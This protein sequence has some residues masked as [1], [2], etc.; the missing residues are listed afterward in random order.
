MNAETL[1]Q[2]METVSEVYQNFLVIVVKDGVLSEKER[3][4]YKSDKIDGKR[5]IDTR[6]A[7]LMSLSGKGGWCENPEDRKIREKYTNVTLL[8]HLLSV[9]RGSMVLA[10]WYWNQ[11]DEMPENLSRRLTGMAA[12]AFLHDLDKVKE[13]QRGET[14]TPEM[15]SEALRVYRIDALLEDAGIQL[16]ASQILYLIGEVEDTQSKRYLS[17]F[18]P[19]RGLTNDCRRFVKLADKLDSIWLQS[20][21]EGGL[22][23]VRQRIANNESLKPDW[24]PPLREINIYDPLHPFLLDELQASLFEASSAIAKIPPL[25]ESHHDG[26]LQV[27]LFEDS[28]EGVIEDAMDDFMGKLPFSLR[29][30][31]SNRGVPQL[32]NQQAGHRELSKFLSKQ[33][34]SEIAKL[35]LIKADLRGQVTGDL[36][37]LLG[38]LGL[39]PVWP[40]KTT[41]LISPFSGLDDLE[42]SSLD[43]LQKAGHLALLLEIKLEKP[44]EVIPKPEERETELLAGM[45]QDRPEWLESVEDGASRRKLTA[46]WVMATALDNTDLENK[47]WGNE[48]FLK[49]WLEGT[50]EQTGFRDF[51]PGESS[52]LAKAVELRFQ[53]LLK[54]KRI[55]VEDEEA[56]HHCLFSNEPVTLNKISQADELYEVK[57]SAFSGRDGRLEN[58]IS[59]QSDTHLGPVAGAE[60]KL[61]HGIFPGGVKSGVPT[62]LS[63]PAT[64]GIFGG[65]SL[66]RDHVLRS[67]SVYDLSRQDT[68]KGR[69]YQGWEVHRQRQRL[70][71]YERLPERLE[72]QVNHFVLLLRAALRLGRPVH[73]F[74][75]LPISIRDFFFCDA[76]PPVLEQLFMGRG[77]RIEQIEPALEKLN[78][79]K[80]LLQTPGLGYEL[81]R[82]Y[83]QEQTRFQALCLIYCRLRDRDKDPERFFRNQ[84]HQQLYT[85]L[86]GE[87]MPGKDQPLVRFGRAA[88]S[89]QKYPMSSSTSKEMLVFKLCLDA[90]LEARRAGQNDSLSLTYAITDAL[91]RN[92]VRK[93]EAAKRG[94]NEPPLRERCKAVAEQFVNDIWLGACEGKPPSQARKRI[95]GS[96]YRVAFLEA[97]AQR[98]AKN[99]DEKS[100][101][102]TIQQ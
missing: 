69:V 19:P 82:L 13:L 56:T 21:L 30:V 49:Q 74:R 53:N 59:D 47:I 10:V 57:V 29:L 84:L 5:R 40:T 80:L 32:R 24:L 101:N 9:V 43:M 26:R 91:E 23:G 33:L 65:L 61:R 92:L 39:A 34:S 11:Q 77:L 90:V 81:M 17:E 55:E 18:P 63:S 7:R 42:E 20:G 46:L 76:L 97:V 50:E 48:G 66:P 94:Q 15:V 85:S 3:H 22:E 100:K 8:D 52:V 95:L 44:A 1:R 36:D 87:N 58:M 28:A 60:H 51:I 12:I 31:V 41:G 4:G 35:F 25:F 16:E 67:L 70:L 93:K 86:E 98:A 73:I 75:G 71:R 78:F 72:D 54:G 64:Q 79:V 99:R 89:I 88:A 45:E 6:V 27:V 62:L 38:P 96:I 14:L 102:E 83:A 68:Q 2:G 37:G